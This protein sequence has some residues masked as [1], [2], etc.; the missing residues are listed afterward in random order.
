LFNRKIKLKGRKNKMK[1]LKNKIAAITIVIFFILS[2]TVSITLIPTASAHNPAWQIPTYAYIS[3]MPNPIGVGQQMTCYVW[4]SNVY[5]SAAIGN[6]YRFQNYQVVITAP[7]G[8]STTQN[9]AFIADSTSSQLFYFTPDQVGT[10]IFNFTFPGQAITTSNDLPTSAYINDTYLPSSASTTLTVQQAPIPA[11]KGSSPLPTAFWERPIFGENDYWYTITSNWLGTGSPQYFAINYDKNTFA[12]DNVGSKTGHVMW[13]KPLESGGVVGGNLFPGSPG[14]GY[15]EGSAYNNRY[16]NPI[17]MDGMLFYTEPIS[18]AATAGV[19]DCVNLVTGQLIWSRSDVPVISFGYIY[20]LWDPNQHGTLQPLLCTTNFARVFDAFT[21]DPLFNVT[22][23]PSGT[24]VLG[25]NGEQLKYVITNDGNATNPQWY[26]AEW[27]STKLWQWTGM[28]PT[29]ANASLVGPNGVPQSITGGTPPAIPTPPYNTNGGISNTYVVTANCANPASPYYNYDWNISLP[30]L[31]VMGNQTASTVTFA[32]GTTAIRIG[33]SATGANPDASNPS[34]VI[35]G[36]YNDILLCRNGSLSS[37]G[38]S[39]YGNSYTP[40]TYFGVDL[41]SAHSTLGNIMW[42]QTFDPA[43][44]NLTVLDSGV[45]PVARV[46]Y[47]SYKELPE[48]VAYS[49]N[50]GQKLWGP[51]AEQPALDYYGNDFGGDLDAQCAYGRLYSVGFAGILYCYNETNGDLLWTYGNGGEGNST[52]A[53][54]NTFYGDYPTFIQAIGDGIIYT[55]TTEHTI[56]DPIYKGA[57]TR[58]INATDGT[59]IWTLP[60]Y[61]GGG[62]NIAEYAIADGYT[63]FFNGYDDQIYVVGRGPSATTVTAP[64]AGLTFGQSVVIRGTVTD[65]SSGTKQDQQAANFPNGVPV[66]SDSSMSDWMGYVYQQKPLP[67][68]FTGVPVTIAVLDSNGNYRTIGT[69]T[70][71][72]SS[73]YCLTWIPDIPGTYTVIATFQGAKGYWSSYSETAFNVMNAP[74]VTL[75]AQTYPQQIDNTM[76]IVGVG[77]AVLVAIA[78]VGVVMVMMIRKRP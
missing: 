7:D 61:T 5:D 36:F 73:A 65:I 20:N 77:V 76:T 16:A 29:L 51:T 39:F 75:T 49:M 24:T 17:I 21:G 30:W 44:G 33:Y 34:T 63:T 15:F 37:M 23:V 46:F 19:T 41:N 71:D 54:L 26:M 4:L 35:A 78:I 72:A 18:F 58:A 6:N 42:M 9:F 62:T 66:S 47:E 13:T 74:A 22:N 50:T 59:E 14:V 60:A 57:L 69:A 45:D 64:N 38:R 68:N 8:T 3:V 28:S 67:T 70:T 11:A 1:T 27:N 48:Y 10:Y 40:Y 2:M 12:P 32:N 25:P 55:D 52:Y 43:P 53:G 31:N 56:T